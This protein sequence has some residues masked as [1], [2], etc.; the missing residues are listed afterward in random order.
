MTE[1]PVDGRLD[2]CSIGEAQMEE[3]GDGEEDVEGEE[4]NIGVDGRESG[5]RDRPWIWSQQSS[6]T[7]SKTTGDV[8]LSNVV[9]GVLRGGK[10]KSR[11]ETSRR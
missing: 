10:R 3:V 4:T 2:W 5:V 9:I 6:H 11:F 7:F 1:T 8:G